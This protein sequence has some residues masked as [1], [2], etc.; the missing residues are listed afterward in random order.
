MDGLRLTPRRPF[1]LVTTAAWRQTRERC[2][3]WPRRRDRHSSAY[4]TADLDRTR[5]AGPCGLP[6]GHTSPKDALPNPRAPP[7]HSLTF[8]T[9][10]IVV[11]N[12]IPVYQRPR[13]VLGRARGARMCR[14]Q[15]TRCT[16]RVPQQV[17]TLAPSSCAVPPLL[18]GLGS[19]S[20]NAAAGVCF[21]GFRAIW[22]RRS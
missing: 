9:K 1:M 22:D 17:S 13:T 2:C 6:E 20:Q 4:H 14:C 12:A 3:L 19:D 7:K 16:E 10:H 15:A 5:S 18:L 11:L 21:S 8:R